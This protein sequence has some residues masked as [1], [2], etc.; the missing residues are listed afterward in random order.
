MSLLHPLSECGGRW[1]TRTV[2]DQEVTLKGKLQLHSQRP[3]PRS[4]QPLALAML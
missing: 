1:H 4:R 3:G 2:L